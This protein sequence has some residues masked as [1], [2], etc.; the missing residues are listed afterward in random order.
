MLGS[1]TPPTLNIP[2]LKLPLASSPSNDRTTPMSASMQLDGLMAKL[3]LYAGGD[4]EGVLTPRVLEK[5]GEGPKTPLPITERDREDVHNPAACDHA[6]NDCFTPTLSSISL[7]SLSTSGASTPPMSLHKRSYSSPPEP[8]SPLRRSH[9]TPSRRIS[10][11][12]KTLANT[13][14]NLRHLAKKIGKAVLEWET[15]PSTI[16]IVTKIYDPTLVR[17]TRDLSSYLTQRLGLKVYVEERLKSEGFFSEEDEEVGEGSPRSYCTADS[18]GS[19]A[20]KTST[21]SA[22]K[23][24]ELLQFWTTEFC[25]SGEASQSVDLVIT[26]GGDG[27]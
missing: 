6:T 11:T 10:T 18:F 7:P 27:T 20:R 15:P 2:I 26:L 8:T 12:T 4:D 9:S 17:T 14:V 25:T 22:E 19:F 21:G 16:L 1:S 3:G 5:L 13:S 24:E 23:E